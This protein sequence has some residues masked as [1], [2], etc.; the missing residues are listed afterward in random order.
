[1]VYNGRLGSDVRSYILYLATE[2]KVPV[3]EIA[4]KCKVSRPTV[5]RIKKQ[6]ENGAK[7]GQK[8]LN[9]GGRPRKISQRQRRILVRKLHSLRREVGSF[10]TNRLMDR[11]G[12]SVSE[13]STRTVRRT[14]HQMG[15]HFLQAR[16][17]G[18]LTEKDR[19][20]RRRFA[21]D[22]IKEH[23]REVWTEKIAFY[24]DGVSFY[25]K[26]NPA[27]QAR[28]PSGRIWRK[29]NEGLSLYCTAKGSKEGSGGKLVK[30]IVAISHEKGV[31]ACQQYEHLDA[32]YFN[33]FVE[34]NFREMFR[35]AGKGRSKLW[36][37]DG[38]PRQ[39]CALVKRT[40]NRMRTNLV[41]IPP[42]SPDINPI[43]NIFHLV[44]KSLRDEA[45]LKNITKE[46]YEDFSARVID[47]V[48]NFPAS[49][50][51]KTIESMN[52]RLELISQTKG[53]RTKY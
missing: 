37:Q 15:Y 2:T 12:L 39:N 6:F 48:T 26:R 34:Q 29:R 21:K 43:E 31:V 16:K 33:Y 38:D 10:S 3:A 32:K 41:S 20:K 36:V 35:K 40:L 19:L 42:R 11:A 9:K 44:K 13:M 22:A 28:A 46:S 17:K 24:L 18:I 1:M 23:G 45:I 51:D 8:V 14:L 7:H 25:Y 52:H 5:Y 50:I 27:D 53:D 47:T 30:L 4:R 49:I